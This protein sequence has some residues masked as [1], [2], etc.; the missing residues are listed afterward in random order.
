[1]MQSAPGGIVSMIFRES[2]DP[3]IDV[4]DYLRNAI[5]V[6]GFNPKGPTL[7]MV[8]KVLQNAPV[9]KDSEGNNN[10]RDLNKIDPDFFYREE[11]KDLFS[12]NQGRGLQVTLSPLNQMGEEGYKTFSLIGFI[13]AEPLLI[14][15]YAAGCRS[16]FS[17]RQTAIRSKEVEVRYL[18]NSGEVTLIRMTSNVGNRL[19]EIAEDSLLKT[20][21]KI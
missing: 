13:R 19:V 7:E 17:R 1:M 14:G 2:L 12:V 20:T 10:V 11:L 18:H 9:S 8:K 15:L 3:D 16:S 21:G 5:W 4:A 6:D